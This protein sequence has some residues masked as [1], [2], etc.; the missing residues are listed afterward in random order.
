M[1]RHR[2][3]RAEARAGWPRYR[4]PEEGHLWKINVQIGGDSTGDL[5]GTAAEG[6]SGPQNQVT[7]DI[8]TAEAY[9][10]IK[11]RHVT[12]CGGL[13][14]SKRPLVLRLGSEESKLSVD[15]PLPF[16]LIL[17]RAPSGTLYKG[18]LVVAIFRTRDSL[19]EELG[20]VTYPVE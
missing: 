16:M 20:K 14:G 4:R 13:A 5:V 18:T 11:Y 10:A 3:Y 7:V 12:I 1:Q 19:A 2:Q 9:R 15:I 6:G 17:V 8:V